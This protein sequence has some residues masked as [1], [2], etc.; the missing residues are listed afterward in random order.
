M[1]RTVLDGT[2]TTGEIIRGY[3]APFAIR[4]IPATAGA[5]AGTIPTGTYVRYAFDQIDGEPVE[6]TD[7]VWTRATSD[8]TLDNS[9]DA[10]QT[11]QVIPPKN[12]VFQVITSAS[13]PTAQISSLARIG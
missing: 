6:D 10:G 12:A 7:L 4:V 2:S 9:L 11:K 8:F 5:T 13:G 3:I 1:A